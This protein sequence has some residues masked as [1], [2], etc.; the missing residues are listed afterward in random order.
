[1]KDEIQVPLSPSE[2]VPAASILI[3]GK[4]VTWLTRLAIVVAALNLATM[5]LITFA[6]VTLR[7]FFSRP[8]VGSA[9][10]TQYLMIGT[11]FLGLGICALEKQHIKV[12]LLVEHFPR[13]GQRVIDIINYIVVIGLSVILGWQSYAQSLVAKMLNLSGQMTH[14]PQ[15]PFYWIVTFGYLLLA[16]A[17]LLL[18]VQTVAQGVKK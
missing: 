7:Y 4:I 16:V 15:Y 14:I 13:R 5:V 11:G 3:A 17:A 9:E 10:L 8:I 2:P 12:E 1:M 18:L 6:D